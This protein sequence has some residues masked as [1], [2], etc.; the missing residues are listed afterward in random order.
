MSQK[1]DSIIRHLPAAFA[2]LV[3]RFWLVTF[4]QFSWATDIELFF[5]PVVSAENEIHE[6]LNT[7]NIETGTYELNDG[8]PALDTGHNRI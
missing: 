8:V 7:V 5:Y 1:S 2:S 3:G 6:S 4:T